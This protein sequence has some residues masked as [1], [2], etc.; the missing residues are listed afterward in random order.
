MILG[1][2]ADSE[3]ALAIFKKKYK[4]NFTFLSDPKHS[5]IEAYGM[6]RTKKFMGRSYKGIVRG[7]VLIGPDARIEKIWDNVKAKGHAAAVLE[8]VKNLASNG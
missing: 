7:T 6:W 1:M 2:S 5:T 8:E 4:F 3:K